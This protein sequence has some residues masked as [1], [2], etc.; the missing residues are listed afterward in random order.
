[1]TDSRQ[2]QGESGYGPSSQPPQLSEVPPGED[3]QFH[4][5]PPWE[6]ASSWEVNSEWQDPSPGSGD[7]D[8]ADD[9]AGDAA[10]RPP[11]T[12]TETLT[13]SETL[14][15]TETLTA[16]ETPTATEK[17]SQ[18]DGAIEPH[19]EEPVPRGW[20][21]HLAGLIWLS[22]GVGLCLDAGALAES[23]RDKTGAAEGLFWLAILVPF[24]AQAVVLLAARPSAR[25][26]GL[27]IVLVGVYPTII[28]RLLSPLVL[29]NY[30]EHLHQRELV[31][32]LQ[33]G[34]LFKPNPLLPIGPYYPGLELFTGTVVRLTG[35]SSIVAINLVPVL[36]RLLFI[37]AL[38]FIAITVV[39]SKRAASLAVLLYAASPEYFNFTSK[40]AYETIALTLAM[41]AVLIIRRAQFE[42]TARARRRLM[43][44]ADIALVATVISHHVTSWIT[45]AFLVAWSIVSPP[46]RRK[47]VVQAT[48]VM[49]IVVVVWTAAIIGK[50]SGY[51]GPVFGGAVSNLSG[52]LGHGSG[53]QLFTQTTG[54]VNPEWQRLLLVVYAVL[55]T[56]GAIVYGGR[57]LLRAIRS[58][59]YRAAGMG[60]L[61]LTYPWTLA[62]HFVP[63]AAQIGDRASAFFFLPFA[64]CVSVGVIQDRRKFW[65][66]PTLAAKGAI[67]ALIGLISI[68]YL[69]G[70]ILGAGASS[71][72]LPGSY[73]VESDNRSQDPITLAAV[74]WAS[75]HIAPGSRIMADRAPSNLFASED[76]LWPVI[77]DEGK[78]GPAYLYFS[79]TWGAYQ[80]ELVKGLNINY[81]YVDTRLAT[82]WP[83]VGSYFYTGEEPTETRLTSADLAKFA[84]EPGLKAVFH[85]GPVTIYSTPGFH[86]S[87]APSGYTGNRSMGL[88]TIGDFVLGVLLVGII[89]A[90]RSRLRWVKTT[91]R[92]A[93]AVGT[94]VAVM[95]VTIIVA[96][97][98]FELRLIPGPA[99]SVG[100]IGAVVVGAI[101]GR[102]RGRHVPL[103]RFSL[104]ALLRPLT[105]VDVLLTVVGVLLAI[106]GI[107]LAVRVSWEIDLTQV[108]TLLRSVASR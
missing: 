24:L 20:S 103:P 16:P 104:S 2:H 50:L 77:A 14:T 97:V 93:G 63:Q 57:V 100:A 31:D 55:C 37:L 11:V 53:G 38:Y 3:D 96:A 23:A 105:V 99:F 30:D 91:A 17:P 94:A 54:Y 89:F 79:S 101:I 68:V 83:E 5:A 98:L 47:V 1:V 44:L 66:T 9:A 102:A 90:L 92:E 106:V 108:N 61:A 4:G 88:G 34:G 27:A 74:Q 69:G 49:A 19:R 32:L 26:R 13:A 72:I 45:L 8:A 80:T 40:F 12:A 84:H 65:P 87:Q 22:V 43:V 10:P 78:L 42:T 71:L 35:L 7:G 60:L 29:Y 6:R 59:E 52:V 58:R 76:R 64:L 18:S 41:G 85:L 21:K 73:A 48:A 51:L 67:V 70:L 56:I 39:R 95:A 28:Y 33:G 82:N 46:S 62:A 81:I 75:T 36:C 86:V 107:V 25:L 15:A